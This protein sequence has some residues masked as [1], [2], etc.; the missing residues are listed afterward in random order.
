MFREDTTT[1][2]AARFIQ[3]N[4]GRVDYIV[5][6]KWM[7]VADRAMLF[8]RGVPITYDKWVSMKNGPV[9]SKTYDLIKHAR[10]HEDTYWASFI[11]TEGYEVILRRDPGNGALS[12]S[13]DTIIEETY[14]KLG[15]IEKWDLVDLTHNFPEWKDPTTKNKKMIPIEL[16][17]ILAANDE[18]SDMLETVRKNYELQE[19]VRALVRGA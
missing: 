16:R 10:T 11:A 17:D 8:K 15:S 19:S 7:Y 4:G 18:P 6:L 1:Q 13:I 5:L 2:M 3:L 12:P 9:L 14:N